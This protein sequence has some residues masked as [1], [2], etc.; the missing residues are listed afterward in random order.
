LRSGFGLRSHLFTLPLSWFTALP[1]YARF[2]ALVAP[3]SR[4]SLVHWFWLFTAHTSCT[5]THVATAPSRFHRTRVLRS[6][7][8][9]AS[10][11][12]YSRSG[13]LCT[14]FLGLHGSRSLF[15]CPSYTLLHTF[16]FTRFA[17]GSLWFSF[18]CTPSHH[19]HFSAV[20][21]IVLVRSQFTLRLRA[22]KQVSA[23]PAFCVLFLLSFRS[24]FA[25]LPLG[26][27]RL[28]PPAGYCPLPFLVLHTHYTGSW[29]HLGW[30]ALPLWLHTRFAE[31]FSGFVRS[32]LRS[33]RFVRFRSFVLISFRS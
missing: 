22:H 10:L 4:F 16:W 26:S 27:H 19:T 7:S 32:F 8:G 21:H 25:S 33:F 30:V 5:H 20:F 6:F 15:A 12:L 18:V 9:F 31:P 3:P 29:V 1:R 17:P 14:L 13:F 11:V 23:P 28:D 24:T 2:V